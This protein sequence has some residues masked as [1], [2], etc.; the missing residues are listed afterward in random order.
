MNVVQPTE[1]NNQMMLVLDDKSYNIPSVNQSRAHLCLRLLQSRRSMALV[2]MELSI[3][4]TTKPRAN[5]H[6]NLYF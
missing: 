5:V 2:V 1:N 6:H 3:P 4:L